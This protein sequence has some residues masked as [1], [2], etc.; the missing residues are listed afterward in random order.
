MIVFVTGDNDFAIKAEVDRLKDEFIKQNGDVGLEQYDA[1]ELEINRLSDLI[2]G[3]SLFSSKRLII[4]RDI[5]DNKDLSEALAERADK[6]DDATDLILV[7]P[8]PD[9]RTRW[10]NSLKKYANTKTA[11]SGPAL[12]EWLVQTAKARGVE[13]S[14]SDARYL[15]T[16]VGED[17]WRLS[18][19]VDKLAGT[20]QPVNK[21]LMDKLIEPSSE[22]NIFQLV[23][24]VVKGEVGPATELY[25]KLRLAD[26]DPHQFIGTLGWQLNA[27]VVIKTNPSK[28]SGQIASSSG[29]SPYVVDRV[30]PLANKVSP[31]DL[32]DVMKLVLDADFDMKQ[33]GI[34][35]DQRAKLL[36]AQ[37]GQTIS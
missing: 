32:R 22:E 25:D 26:V 19:E 15:I 16:L 12:L 30:R 8:K 5:G 21:Q 4:I 13:L 24:L 27:L 3:S 23:D 33:T 28:T 31:D 35:A 6:I 14:D 29:L 36:I 7:Q 1:K 11:L 2:S 34:D 20:S 37:L 10:F 9:K 17:Q 18:S